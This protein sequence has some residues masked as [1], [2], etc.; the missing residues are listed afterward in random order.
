MRLFTAIDI[1]DRI[2]LRVS[3]LLASLRPFA[4]LAWSP[5]E[6]LHV[7]TKFIGEWPEKSLDDVVRGLST[8]PKI[9][10][11]EVTVEGLGWFPNPHNPR[12]LWAGIKGNSALSLLAS[13]T[14]RILTTIGVPTESK[15]FHPHLTLARRRDA[16]PVENLKTEISVLSS[17]EHQFGSFSADSFILYLSKAGRYVKLHEFPLT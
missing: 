7:T 4:K 9:G 16:T 12:V 6:N 5:V 3:A 8:A 2:K 14:D 10:L 1:P 17:S 11:I 13:E 15:E